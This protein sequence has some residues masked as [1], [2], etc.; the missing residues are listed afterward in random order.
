MQAI[1]SRDDVQ[2]ESIHELVSSGV[3]L[4]AWLTATPTLVDTSNDTALMGTAAVTACT[5]MPPPETTTTNKTDTSFRPGIDERI[6]DCDE[7]ID[8]QKL[9]DDMIAARKAQDAGTL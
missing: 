2:V 4:P 3:D 8:T 7:K 1:E 5:S 6:T 9:V